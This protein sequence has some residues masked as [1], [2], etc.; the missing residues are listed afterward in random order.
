VRS[1][2]NAIIKAD[3]HAG[4]GGESEGLKGRKKK[5]EVRQGETGV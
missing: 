3:R 4:K 1:G 2:K 5:E